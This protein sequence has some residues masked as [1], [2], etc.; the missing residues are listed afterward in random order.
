MSSGVSRVVTGAYIGTGSALSI[1][2]IGF[3]PRV[4]LLLNEDDPSTVTMTDTL[5][6]DGGL[7]QK[8]GTTSL[9]GSNGVTLTNAGFDV[10]T[11]A[12]LNTDGETVHFVAYE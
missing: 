11:D 8:G 5:P 9:I 12:D 2:K 6:A 10:G 3:Q 4:L 1:A 7:K